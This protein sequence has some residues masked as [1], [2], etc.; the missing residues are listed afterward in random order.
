MSRKLHTILIAAATLIA[1]TAHATDRLV[2]SQYR[3][4]QAAVDAAGPGETVRI[5]RGV[6]DEHVVVG[7]ENLTLKGR[8]GTRVR[9]MELEFSHGTNISRLTFTGKTGAQLSM[10]DCRDVTISNCTFRK[11]ENGLVADRCDSL[12]VTNGAFERLSFGAVFISSLA[13]RVERSSFEG[14]SE[15]SVYAMEAPQVLVEGC[16]FKSTAGVAVSRSDRHVI[17]GNRLKNSLIMAIQSDHGLIENNRISKGKDL[18]IG[19]MDCDGTVIQNNRLARCGSMGIM[20]QVGTDNLLHANTIK[21]AKQVGIAMM[22]TGN[23]IQFNKATKCGEY[24][25][26]D[27]MGVGANLYLQN[28]FGKTN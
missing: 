2:P 23:T 27:E 8:S 26:R 6:Y 3:T 25:L 13:P 21:A 7:K 5:S 10:T 20:V 22:S 1:S 18:G 17:R 19:I 4:I 12:T 28:R 14:V 15:V 16:M 11:G 24:D 9:S